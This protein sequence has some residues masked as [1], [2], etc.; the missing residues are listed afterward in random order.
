M[1]S[2]GAQ[3]LNAAVVG[4]TA[5]P[6]GGGY[7]LVASDGGVFAF[8]DAPWYGS[9][10]GTPLPYK[11]IGLFSVEVL[12]GSGVFGYAVVDASGGA[13]AF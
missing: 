10:E 6:S 13:E 12:A 1:G 5:L 3:R 7:W 11:V 4:V 9:R 8:G 2:M